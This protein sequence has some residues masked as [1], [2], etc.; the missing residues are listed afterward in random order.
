MLNVE[1]WKVYI[2][3][4]L[5]LLW[6]DLRAQTSHNSFKVNSVPFRIKYVFVL[7]YCLRYF[8][9]NY[10]LFHVYVYKQGTD[11]SCAE[12]KNSLW[13]WQN[14][15]VLIRVV[16]WNNTTPFSRLAFLTSY[17][18][19]NKNSLFKHGKAITVLARFCNQSILTA[20]QLYEHRE[21]KVSKTSKW[22][23]VLSPLNLLRHVVFG[24][25]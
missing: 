7:F 25:R 23:I 17:F 20:S 5:I 15:N 16:L 12:V 9:K 6:E 21:M 19:L 2:K 18:I 14:F 1:F 3:W 11:L 10:L 13:F 8:L 24:R 22:S 4:C